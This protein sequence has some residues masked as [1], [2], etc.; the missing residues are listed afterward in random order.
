MKLVY[1]LL[2]ETSEC[3]FGIW[4]N[5]NREKKYSENL[6]YKDMEEVHK[7]VHVSANLLLKK[8]AMD[9][10]IKKEEIDELLSKSS[11]LMDLLKIIQRNETVDN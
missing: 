4:L 3:S 5:E 8:K 2:L 6:Y 7:S 11:L 10:I 1:C 9:K